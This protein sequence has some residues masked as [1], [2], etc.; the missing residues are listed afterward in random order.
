MATKE[1][2]GFSSMATE[3]VGFSAMAT[4][5]LVGFSSMATELEL[6]STMA[7]GSGSKSWIRGVTGE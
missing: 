6:L 3:L 2:V 4:K 5:E 7:G 1:L